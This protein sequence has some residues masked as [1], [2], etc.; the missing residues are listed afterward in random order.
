MPRNRSEVDKYLQRQ[1]LATICTV[2]S[3]GRPHGVPVHFVYDEGNFY[4]HTDRNSIKVRN[5]LANPY[6]AIVVYSGEE[7]V[8]ARG[9]A[10]IIEENQFHSRTLEFVKKYRY[11]VNDEREDFYG[12]PLFDSSVRCIVEVEVERLLYW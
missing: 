12:I 4:I 7:A 3:E 8:I 10:R 5:I 6:A 11:G 2:D 1:W 9:S